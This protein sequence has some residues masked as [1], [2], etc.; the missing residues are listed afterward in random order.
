MIAPTEAW[1]E[2][3]NYDESVSATNGAHV[4]DLLW[5]R[6]VEV[7]SGRV[8]Y[9]TARRL[10]TPLAVQH[11]SQWRLDLDARRS[12]LT[13]HWLRI[14][15]GGEKIDQ[16]KR[17]RMRL[18]QRETQLEHHVI[19]GS[20]TLLVVL[21]DVRPGD[22]IEAGYTVEW[23]H[24]IR[25]EGCEVFFVVPPQAKVA[26]FRLVVSSE[27]TRG[28]LCW[29]A[30]ADAPAMREET[31]EDGRRRWVWEGEQL[32]PR[33]PEPNQPTT[34]LDYI[35]VQVSDLS[36]W[37][38]LATR[39]ELAWSVKNDVT[40]IEEASV[41]FAKP[42]KVDAEAILGLVRHVQDGFRYL[43]MDL[44]TSG[45]IPSAPGVVARRRHGDC[46]DL[47][48]LV[49]TVLKSWGVKSRPVLVGT[50]LR[51]RVASLLPM[52]MLFNHAI[53]EV[54]WA[55]ATRWF[56]LTCRDMGGGFG[57]QV[58]GWFGQGLVIDGE[59]GGLVA[60]PGKRIGG[61]YD[62][63]ETILLDTTRNGTSVVEVR[64]RVEGWHADNLRRS[65]LAQG[66]ENF[67]KERDEQTRLR[68]GHTRR[69]GE[70]LWRDDRDGNVCELVEVFELSGSVY[71]GE[72]GKR[73]LFDVPP[74]LIVQIFPLPN[75][76]ARR[77]P[78]D[79]P[80]PF[81]VAHEVQVKTASLGVGS[82]PRRRWSEIEFEAIVEGSRIRGAW[83]NRTR[84]VVGSPEVSVE[85]LPIF[86]KRMEE[87]FR[88]LGW[89]LYLPW[90]QARG[91]RGDGFGELAEPRAELI[92][93]ASVSTAGSVRAVLQPSASD[94][95]AETS[96]AEEGARLVSLQKSRRRR[97][98]TVS[99][100]SDDKGHGEIKNSGSKRF[101]GLVLLVALALAV[102][103]V[104]TLVRGCIS[105]S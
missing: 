6:Q 57:E 58:V 34:F 79:M 12:R 31:R 29:K 52:A 13:L 98:S 17:E 73:A 63:R 69:M 4:T 65:R 16:L 45:W 60:Q 35:W 56:D 38:E 78:W 42:E 18:M 51:E 26:R 47:A 8:F 80:F 10:E 2:A 5:A 104:V 44:E 105:A 86:R 61:R 62:M 50:G 75:E 81:E 7:G 53:V 92:T 67:T 27:A 97:R 96:G 100:R 21:E 76:G 33:E 70:L 20:W 28:D 94:R 43:S 32:V 72:R 101:G 37:A 68:Y 1:V 64:L 99:R 23:A 87:V 103:L 49:A 22:V 102:V 39:T 19:D 91:R 9:A 95:A 30:S 41:V 84:L 90:G 25:P 93:G 46:K 36:D 85:R 66:T 55:G 74:S 24:P 15:R 82:R 77:G 40:G 48:W 71:P 3:E 14:V 54:E 11:E 88:E 59:G 83:V 89:R